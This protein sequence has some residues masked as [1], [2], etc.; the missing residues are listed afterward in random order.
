[1]KQKNLGVIFSKTT[2]KR[3]GFSLHMWL[4][5]TAELVLMFSALELF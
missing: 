5:A 4:N 1:M 2:L 3:A